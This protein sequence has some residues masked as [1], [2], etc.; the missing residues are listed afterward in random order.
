LAESDKRY[1][2]ENYQ[3]TLFDQPPLHEELSTT[4]TMASSSLTSASSYLNNLLLARGLLQDGKSIDFASN[5]RDE[6]TTSKIINIVHDLVLRR[7]RDAEQR[8]LLAHNL[9]AMRVEESQR[10]LDMQRVQ[11]KNADLVRKMKEA[12]A[13]E[14]ALRTSAKKAENAA[15]EMKE[16]M[17]K[18]KSTLDQVRAKCL[19]DVRKRD[20]DIEKLQKQVAQMQ[21]GQRGANDGPRMK[22]NSL[23]GRIGHSV[24]TADL[25]LEQESS[26]F[27][28]ALLNETSGENVA[29]RRI[30]TEA[31]DT[32]REMT[33]M[34]DMSANDET[35]LDGI[36]IPGQYRKSRQ[37]LAEK[38]QEAALVSCERLAKDIDAALEHCRSI[39][40]DP[41]F[42]PIEEVQVR[43]EEIGKLRDG[44][45]RMALRWKEAVTM[46]ETWRQNMLAG[47]PEKIDV[48]ELSHLEFGRSVALLPDG[49]P[50]LSREEIYSSILMDSSKI[51]APEEEAEDDI[52]LE[53]ESQIRTHEDFLAQSNVPRLFPEDDSFH[54]DDAEPSPKRLAVSPR[55][56]LKLPR[57]AVTLI[58]TSG[59][60]RTNKTDAEEL[61]L[62]A[63][64]SHGNDSGLGNSDA[65]GSAVDVDEN[66]T[67]AGRH[68]ASKIP[69]ATS[70]LPAL[71]VSEKLAAVEAEA[72]EAEEERRRQQ[73][74][75]THKRKM[76]AK[77][78]A[79]VLRR[80]RR[81]STLAPEEL[82]ELM[83]VRL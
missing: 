65:S 60:A 44:W 63:M 73:E 51:E 7:D 25:G 37:K 12:D 5:E 23:P 42:V 14:R 50:V 24:N 78:K 56:G 80:S 70:Q 83:T 81:R 52:D 69:K 61:A 8:E 18:M 43:D 71:T 20:L 74:A 9:R 3:Q 35:E 53:Q 2:Y 38:E 59:N 32:L 76:P 66:D 55:R 27:L 28:A 77:R 47:S 45:E 34:N 21:R 17:L 31:L 72:K 22:Q 16:Q 48:N 39:L 49:K 15:K 79:D 75:A 26:D 11:D 64:L 46:M 4:S 13:Q 54:P 33:G 41:S 67:F 58:E 57:P 19:Q 62:E 1:Q 10:V 82:R 40:R 6:T 30:V 29:L 36:G 68:V